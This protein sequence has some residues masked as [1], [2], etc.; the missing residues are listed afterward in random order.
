MHDAFG[1]ARRAR[2]V[3][4]EARVVLGSGGGLERGGGAGEP[5]L[6]ADLRAAGLAR[7]DDHVLE[8]G[9]PGEDGPRLGEERLGDDRDLGPAVVQEVQIVLRPHHGVDGDGNRPDLDR[10]PEGGQEGGRV[11]EEAEHALL[12][13]D[14]ELAQGVARAVDHLLEL[15]VRD[16]AVLGEEGRLAPA[17]FLHVAVHEEARGIEA[18]RDLERRHCHRSS[19]AASRGRAGAWPSRAEA[20]P[21]SRA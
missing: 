10:P 18:V 7:D 17:P 6:E 11:E 9:R 19:A 13:L 2:G 21:S 8:M 14:T 15:G 20:Q 1:E 3:Q 12:R 16:L 5:R 4:P